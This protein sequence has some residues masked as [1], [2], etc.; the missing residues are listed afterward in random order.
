MSFADY[1]VIGLYF[2]LVIAVGVYTR[3][4]VKKSE[5]YFIAGRQFGKF[6][7]AFGNFGSAVS[8]NDIVLTSGQ[9]WRNGFSGI[10]ISLYF[11][12][13][14]PFFWFFYKWFRRLRYV[15]NAD[16]LEDRYGSKLLPGLYAVHTALLMCV[17][18]AMGFT[19]LGDSIVG[20]LRAQ[21]GFEHWNANTIF[22][23]MLTLLS[24]TILTYTVAGGYVAA[25]LTDCVQ[26]VFMIVISFLL[27][28]LALHAA[29]GLHGLRAMVPVH[30]F[31]MLGS[32]QASSF[33]WYSVAALMVMQFA[34]YLAGPSTMSLNA[35]RD[36]RT[37]Q[38]GP[39]AGLFL[40]RICTIGWA[41]TGLT[42]AAV[43]SQTAVS[44]NQMYGTLAVRLLKPLG[45]GLVGFVVAGL[46]AA[47]M[48]SVSA[49]S[50]VAAGALTR[51]LYRPLLAPDRDDRH[52]MQAGRIM[53]AGVIAGSCVVA[54]YVRDLLTMFWLATTV[55]M[56]FGPLFW[57]GLFWRRANKAAAYTSLT[58][59]FL[60]IFALPMALVH[61]KIA[62]DPRFLGKTRAIEVRYENL[63]AT[64]FD[65]A[66]GNAS[67][68]GQRFNLV[69]KGPQEPLFFTKMSV[70]AAGHPCGAQQLRPEIFILYWL[71]Y[72]VSRLTLAQINALKMVYPISIL[73]GSFWLIGLVTRPEEQNR[74]NRFFARLL[75]PARP[76]GHEEEM[77]LIAAA[78]ENYALVRDREWFPH[79]NWVF[80]R[81]D[82]WMRYGF[83]V[84]AVIT[85]AFVGAVWLVRVLV[86]G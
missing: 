59:G 66:S 83:A 45:F 71:G 25:V 28:P 55:A 57:F 16:L 37:A 20:I 84:L 42:A 26:S 40:K 4:R 7:M 50:I 3:R 85:A 75:V 32:A 31:D 82:P 69:T 53:T 10:W 49:T 35:G 48:A 19:A 47:L 13:M 17:V 33:T 54:W 56:L 80:N 41:L 15:T 74:L 44:T 67:A 60:T 51:N 86:K 14:S 21:P 61:T 39:L 23:T 1:L 5:D 63:T 24:L 34:A 36:E 68:V 52:Y 22:L 27:I 78:G 38:I 72:D 18:T 6:L 8:A 62:G 76:G 65:V 11:V 29:G 9:A 79:S 58:V 64:E 81:P 43:L 70:D 77:K 2:A 73:F 12:L 30:M 46:F